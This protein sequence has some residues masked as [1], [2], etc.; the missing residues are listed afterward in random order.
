MSKRALLALLLLSGCDS[1]K[2]PPK[3]VG[4]GSGTTPTVPS[5]SAAGGGGAVGV[6]TLFM[7]L[8][9]DSDYGWLGS[10]VVADIDGDGKQE[11]LAAHEKVMAWR[12]DGS[13][14]WQFAPKV[15]RVWA[16]LVVADFRDGPE[17]ETVVA[18]QG[19]LWMLD[20]K[21]AVLSGWPVTW[22][23]EIR[24][25]AAGDVNGDGQ[26][27][28]VVA[29]TNHSPDILSAYTAAGQQ[30][31]G[32]PPIASGTIGCQ[33]GTNCW[34]AGAF[35]QNLAVGDLDGTGGLDIVAPMDCSYAGFFHGTGVAFDANPMFKKRPKTPGVRYLHTLSQAQ[36]GYADDEDTELQAHFTNTP[37]A[38]ADVDGDGKNEVI[39]LA[40]VQNA[41]QD[42]REKGVAL[43]VV[44]N[45]ASRLP[46]WETPFR[47]PEYVFG[48]WDFDEDN[49]VG[50]TNQV[51]VADIDAT[52]P[53]PE[54]I[55]AGFDARIH[56][57]TADKQELWATTYAEDGRVLTGGVV[58]G[59]LSKDGIPE[60]VF[61]TYSPDDNRSSLFVL[62]AGG[63]V[64]HRV[65]LPQHGAAVPTLADVDGDGAVEIVLSMRKVYWDGSEPAVAIY[66]VANSGTNCLLWPTGRANYLRNGW[67]KK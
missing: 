40:S 50:A 35:D 48:L 2:D 67:V 39:M 5:C 10:P 17:L 16:G 47:A 41:S 53:G 22:R 33:N 64:L 12:A 18:S 54:F 31:Q 24:S 19:Q 8:K 61:A 4:G 26:L 63:H 20:A 15:G 29:S 7:G 46:G 36:Q 58:V 55:F 49:A 6:P 42:D 66:K 59:D 11:I 25:L 14:A 56:A 37:P 1:G 30:I 9:G 52:H 28:V 3:T 44:R 43:W 23:G 60:I 51:V 65:A 38:I 13:V 34:V 57:V 21:G 32:F 62:D 27:D 45:D